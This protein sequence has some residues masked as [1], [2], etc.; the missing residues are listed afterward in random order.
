MKKF[1]K[2]YPG[3]IGIIP[4]IGVFLL[5][6]HHILTS[7]LGN[8][9]R[10]AVAWIAQ[11]GG[12]EVIDRGLAFHIGHLEVPW[13][14]DCAGINLILILLAVYAWQNRRATPGIAY[15]IGMAA[16]IPAALIANIARILVLVGYRWWM[17]PEVEPPQLHYFMGF[18]C[19][20]PVLIP[21]IFLSKYFSTV[22]SDN[23]KSH[24]PTSFGQSIVEC[25]HTVAVIALLAPLMELS[26]HW[27][28]V[29]GV[30]FCLVSCEHTLTKS[31]YRLLGELTLWGLAAGFIVVSQIDS[32]WLPWLLLFPLVR[33]F[34]SVAKPSTWVSLLLACPLFALLPQAEFFAFAA[35]GFILWKEIFETPASPMA[36]SSSPSQPNTG[37]Q[38]ESPYVLA[39]FV[40]PSFITCGVAMLVLPFL[41]GN[42]FLEERPVQDPP[43]AVI[44]E[45]LP[46]MG[47]SIRMPRQH[48]EM[49]L[50][51]YEPQGDSRH[52]A[53][54]VC[55]GYRGIFLLPT[56]APSVKTDDRFW[57]REY[58]LVNGKLV[59]GYRQYL[60]S[61]LGFRRSPG[62]HLIF[63]MPQREMSAHRFAKEVKETVRRLKVEVAQ[64]E[65]DD[66]DSS[67]EG[68]QLADQ[69]DST[70]Y[71]QN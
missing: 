43:R 32:L 65:K 6:T 35:I 4:V 5:D 49:T 64:N 1:L 21:T 62:I 39:L 30:L 66:E 55:L 71:L 40:R 3:W 19:I 12:Y 59:D 24:P 23:A 29:I 7:L 16:L 28:T 27:M 31:F 50:M 37:N 45:E 15:L 20:I 14:G 17:Y 60:W 8:L 22:E 46:G 54:E 70:S 25:C 63:V 34:K 38:A 58:F 48:D 47:Y 13:S 51:W 61:T 53:V 36:P 52:H 68:T 18:A 2:E 9:T 11:L 67:S 69:S 44:E 41:P 10:P 56:D 42:W 57:Y 33:S 26:V